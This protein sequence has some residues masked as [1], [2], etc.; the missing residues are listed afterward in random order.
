[1]TLLYNQYNQVAYQCLSTDIVDGKVQGASWKGADLYVTDIGQ[2]FKVMNDLTLAPLVY[3]VSSGVSGSISGSSIGTAG[4]IS[5][6]ASESHIGQTGGH[7]ILASASF[8][9]TSG[10]MVAY[11]AGDVVSGGSSITTPYEITNAFRI[12]GGSGYITGILVSTNK[13]SIIPR[14]KLHFY[15]A[16]TVTLAGDNL[17]YIDLFLDVQYKLGTF[18]LETMTSGSNTSGSCSS[19]SDFDTVRHP[20]VARQGS[21]S[22][23]IALETLSAYVPLAV[24][25]TYIINLL[26]D[27]N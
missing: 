4:G 12:A 26:I 20:V 21:T 5:L 25:Q 22:L 10:S 3:N 11:Q 7:L 6:G 19:T 1:M 23:Y 24:S 2:W 17:P 14:F 18:S 16:S 9:N 8:V 15:S 13:S 27:N